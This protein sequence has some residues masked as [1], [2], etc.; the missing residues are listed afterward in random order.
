V[1]PPIVASVVALPRLI[2]APCDSVSELEEEEHMASSIF[3]VGV[4]IRLPDVPGVL[5]AT[6]SAM[7]FRFPAGDAVIAEEILPLPLP[8]K[9]NYWK[10]LSE[11]KKLGTGK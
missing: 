10:R 6:D 3:A 5:P 9:H 8:E 1:A 4:R 2:T 7:F 11:T